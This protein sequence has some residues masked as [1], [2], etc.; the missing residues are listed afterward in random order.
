MIIVAI[1]VARSVA[2]RIRTRVSWMT[3]E[4]DAANW[5]RG[6]PPLR[7]DPSRVSYYDTTDRQAVKASLF[8]PDPG[9]AVLL[10]GG[11]S[12]IANEGDP[13]GR[14]VPAHGVYNFNIF[15]GRC[16]VAR[17]PLLGATCDRSNVAARLGDLLVRSGLCSRVLLVPIAHGGT[18]I[19]EW[20]AAG[21]MRPRLLFALKRLN[22]AGIVV[23]HVLWQSGEAEA[24]QTSADAPAWIR[25]FAD[26]VTSIRAHGLT[27]PIYVAQGTICCNGGNE[28]I[29]SAQRAV[30][31]PALGV[32]PGPDLDVIDISKR[33]DGCHFSATGL[34]EAAQLWLACLAERSAERL[35]ASS[36]G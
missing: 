26:I 27:A 7:L 4:S 12:N 14:I 1:A 34:Q 30:C 29:R 35:A 25:D 6:R 32:L 19:R 5:L 17:D 3:T 11:Q 20:T 22:K 24:A 36:H 31:S 10:L 15:D 16:F 28:V 2:I 8:R 13:D 33:W 23:T 18:F 21:R 9:L